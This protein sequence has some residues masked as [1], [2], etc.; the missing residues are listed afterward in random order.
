MSLPQ[1]S[2]TVSCRACDLVIGAVEDGRFIHDEACA[3]PLSIGTGQLRC[4]HCGGRLAG[5]A[6]PV[7]APLPSDDDETV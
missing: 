6:R 5:E 4:C 3:Q 2:W 1:Q 7:P